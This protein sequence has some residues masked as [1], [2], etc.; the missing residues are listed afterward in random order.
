M[1]VTQLAQHATVRLIPSGRF[2]PKA[3][4]PLVD[5]NDELAI[6]EELEGLTSGRLRAEKGELPDLDPRELAYAARARQLQ[7]FGATYVNAAFAYTR[8]GG[9]R[10]N[11]H[12]RGAW[13]CAFD[14]LT[15]VAEVGYHLTRELSAIGVFDNTTDYQAM[16][17]DFIGEFPDLRGASHASLD[18]DPAAG[19][20]VG[21]ALAAA[22]RKAGHNGLIYP[23]VRAPGGTCFAAFAPQIVQNVRPAA[24]W[25]L[26]WAGSPRFSA[27]PNPKDA[28]G[29]S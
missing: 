26:T 4:S 5:H 16:L 2:K 12:G 13:Y 3:L 29:S 24:V 19:Y 15:A 27:T 21:Q 25:R 11:A 17:A 6:L 10:F 20:P 7:Q 23:S 9:N 1:K 28:A 14:D 8:V 18:P 22:L